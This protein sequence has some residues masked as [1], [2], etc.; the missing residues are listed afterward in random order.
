MWCVVCSVYQCV[1]VYVCG[2]GGCVGVSYTVLPF[3]V[4]SIIC[5]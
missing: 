2:G 3:L 5:L 1:Y 4:L